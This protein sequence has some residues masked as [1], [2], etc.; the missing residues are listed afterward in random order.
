MLE[1]R[2]DV[3]GEDLLLGSLGKDGATYSA[4]SLRHGGLYVTVALRRVVD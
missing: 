4:Y 1:S 2:L 3:S